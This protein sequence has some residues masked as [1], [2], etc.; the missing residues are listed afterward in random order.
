[1]EHNGVW[2]LVE[3][4]KGYKLVGCK[5]VFK[6]KHDSHDNLERY[7]ARL[8]VKGFTQKYDIDR[9]FHQSHKRILSG[10]SWD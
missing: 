7:K 6:T 5:W 4:P 3:L 9:R 8:V 10:L 1:M 2:D